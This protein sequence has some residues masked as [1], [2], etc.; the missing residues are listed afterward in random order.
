MAS[1][2]SSKIS[3]LGG[4]GVLGAYLLAQAWWLTSMSPDDTSDDAF[5]YLLLGAPIAFAI[6]WYG[7]P[8][9]VDRL[10][11]RKSRH[12][13]TQARRRRSSTASKTPD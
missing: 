8:F 13:R 2:R 10:K 12:P 1:F 3:Q 6:G 9:V 5:L 7:V 11:P 4:V